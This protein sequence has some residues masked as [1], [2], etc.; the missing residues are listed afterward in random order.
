[1]QWRL[2]VVG[3]HTRSIGKTQLVCDLIAAFPDANWIAGKITQYGHGVCARNGKCCDCAPNEHICALT[4]EKKPSHT[5]SG[6][7]LA[8]GARRSFWLRT[9]QGRLAE[10]MPLLRS[11][12]GDC[13]SDLVSGTQNLILESNTLLEF[14][15][16]SLYLMVVD[17][18][19]PDFKESAR[20]QTSEASAVIL[21][22]PMQEGIANG[23]TRAGWNGIAE[24]LANKPQF[25]QREN[26]L[27]PPE[28]LS[29]MRG[30]LSDGASI[31]L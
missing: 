18:S 13:E 25:L 27:L 1:M 28:L 20:R 23:G 22:R 31:V 9:K 30:T 29:R 15:K 19:K 24:L 16:P 3:G 6:R 8:A 2:I 26:D 11:A 21:R 5:D 17:V 14:V 10:G 4:W 12:L 7:F